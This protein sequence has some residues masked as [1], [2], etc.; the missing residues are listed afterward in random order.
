MSMT[1]RKF[2]FW[3][4]CKMNKIKDIGKG[5]HNKCNLNAVSSL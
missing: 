5:Y 1:G 3:R 4:V 2:L